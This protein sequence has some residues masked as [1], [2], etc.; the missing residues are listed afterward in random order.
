MTRKRT[1]EEATLLL[2]STLLRKQLYYAQLPHLSSPLLCQYLDF[3]DL[4]LEE[5]ERLFPEG[6]AGGCQ[7]A[8]ERA[9]NRGISASLL[10]REAAD[11]LIQALDEFAAGGAEGIEG[12]ASDKWVQ[13]RKTRSYGSGGERGDDQGSAENGVG[14]DKE[15]VLEVGDVRAAA[16][17]A[18]A[19]AA[20]AAAEA[21]A[22]RA[23]E[24]AQKEAVLAAAAAAINAEESS[25]DQGAKVL[26]SGPIWEEMKTL[27]ESNRRPL[28]G[29]QKVETGPHQV[30]TG[31]EPHY[32]W[33]LVFKT[34]SSIAR[35]RVMRHLRHLAAV[36]LSYITSYPSHHAGR[37][38]RKGYRIFHLFFCYTLV[39]G[40]GVPMHLCAARPLW[41][42]LFLTHRTEGL[43]QELRPKPDRAAR[44]VKTC[45]RASWKRQSLVA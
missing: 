39:C 4:R 14:H 22:K 36:G 2:T 19:A 27:A 12:T 21:E 29:A 16:A 8:L 30:R 1:R 17:E 6:L 18:A 44:Q 7:G 38:T 13:L 42:A 33:K 26:G 23:V 11:A 20:A 15:E 28:K 43:G 24:A 10:R 40:F 37:S 35:A 3:V 32:R 41:K 45:A 31:Q 5:E 9:T 34:L 25:G